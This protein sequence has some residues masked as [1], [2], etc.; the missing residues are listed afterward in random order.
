MRTRLTDALAGEARQVAET[1]LRACVH[2][3]MC[4]ATCP[5]YQLTG[6]EL[7][8][9]RGRIYLMKQALEGEPVTDLTR[10]ALDACLG[11]R[12]CETTCPSGVEYHRLFEVGQ[13]SVLEAA[14]RPV[15]GRRT[16]AVIRALA[17]SPA[18][19]LLS[20]LGRTLRPVLPRILRD[21]VPP[22]PGATAR[23][24]V[25]HVRRMVL[26]TGCVQ[27]GAAPHF[28][29]AAARIL[30]RFGI[31]L[32]E[33]PQAGCCGAVPGHLDAREQARMLARRNLD[34]WA[35]LLD[36]GAE[37]VL[38]TSSGCG[39]YLHD[40]PDLLRDDP[41]YADLA[42]RLADRVRDPIEVLEALPLEAAA[43]P[44]RPRIAIHEPCSLQHGLRLA[45]RIPALLRRLGY[46]PLP[47]ADGHLCCGSAG[48]WSLLNPE[49]AGRLAEGRV[50]ALTAQAPD[51]VFTANIGCWMHL[52][53]HA[54][55]PLRHWLE[56][57]EDV[58]PPAR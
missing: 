37:A 29:A 14:P 53:A 51:A 10:E 57:I 16:R 52:S 17:L 12:A 24:P 34:A 8:G 43:P 54:P 58:L 41:A 30:D 25:R 38:A 39:A 6:E 2:C 15:A 40:Y 5:T 28:N 50:A 11:C 49:M 7:M 33:A 48:A 55:T 20:S 46:E 18:F 1:A 9:P 45:G 36:D 13:A 23:P 4:N 42:R 44:A 21:R 27:S 26:L 56:A 32:V 31:S 47:V 3:G 35:P 22:A 19:G